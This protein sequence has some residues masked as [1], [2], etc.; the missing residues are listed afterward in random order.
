MAANQV[1]SE[2]RLLQQDS[3]YSGISHTAFDIKDKNGYFLNRNT[4]VTKECWFKDY[5]CD[6]VYFNNYISSTYFK[7]DG[8]PYKSGRYTLCHKK[9]PGYRYVVEIQ[10]VT[11]RVLVSEKK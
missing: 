4:K 9:L 3:L 10:P 5:G 1:A 7:P 2:L 6:G 8:A 11:G